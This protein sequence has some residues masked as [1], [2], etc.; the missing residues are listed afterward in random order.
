MK[1]LQKRVGITA[2]MLSGIKGIKLT[3]LTK[4]V[5][6]IIQALR[7][8]EIDSAARYRQCIVFF[9]ALGKFVHYI[10]IGLLNHRCNM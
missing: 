5:S 3:G 10:P 7:L 1:E 6:K 9:I 8:A 4:R 2:T